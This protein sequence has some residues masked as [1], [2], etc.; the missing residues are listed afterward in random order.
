MMG[1][2]VLTIGALL[3]AAYVWLMKTIFRYV[4]NR[5]GSNA[6][7]SISMLGI[8]L[9]T[10]GDT[11]FNRWYVANVLCKRED[12]GVKIFETV[13]LEREHWDEI[14]NRAALPLDMRAGKPFLGR[15]VVTDSY[16]DDGIWPLT[17][18]TRLQFLVVDVTTEKVLS[19]FVNYM[20]LGGLWWTF[21]LALFG[22]NPSFDWFVSR[23][24]TSSCFPHQRDGTVTALYGTFEQALRR[25]SP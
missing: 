16:D 6:Y 10:V 24:A 13:K 5:T 23:G 9:L 15:Y 18:H 17:Y 8:F 20:P 1:L 2:F 22:G 25:V 21:P 11:A 3:I 14:N 19:R 12:V 7:A 4:K